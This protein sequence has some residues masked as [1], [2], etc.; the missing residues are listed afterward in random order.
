MKAFPISGNSAWGFITGTLSDQTDLVDSLDAKQDTLVS[1]A[2][3]KTVNGN[4]L[5]GSGNISIS[6]GGGDQATNSSVALEIGHTDK[7]FLNARLTTTEKLALTAV[8]GLEVYDTTLNQKS[9]Y[10]G[11]S[12]IN[13]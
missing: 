3:I 12:W 13:Y 4:S 11:T 10:N 7:G 5:L 2:S 9:Y 6:G 8:A 1:G